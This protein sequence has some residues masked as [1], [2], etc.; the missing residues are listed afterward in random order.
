[1]PRAWPPA[2]NAG[3]CEHHRHRCTQPSRWCG[4]RPVRNCSGL[5]DDERTGM[6][7]PNVF[8]TCGSAGPRR[9]LGAPPALSV[10]ATRPAGPPLP[11]VMGGL[12]AIK[13]TAMGISLN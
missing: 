2:T 11:V 7:P 10:P 1:V 3:V 13:N 5:L 8:T 12:V 6:G 9:C 4:A